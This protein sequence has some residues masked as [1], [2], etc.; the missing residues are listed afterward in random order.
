MKAPEV[1]KHVAT[2]VSKDVAKH[3]S[4][5]VATALC[6]IFAAPLLACGPGAVQG[7]V[8]GEDLSAQDAVVTSVTFTDGSSAA[9]VWIA[10][11][12]NFCTAAAD[13]APLKDTSLVLLQL[14]IVAPDGTVVAA[15]SAGTYTLNPPA[16]KVGER[17]AIGAWFHIGGCLDDHESANTGTVTITHVL[18]T[19]S[20]LAEMA[21]SISLAF[22]HGSVEGNF[23]AQPCAKVAPHALNCR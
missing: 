9:Q 14:G 22:G 23:Q 8:E 6:L 20:G 3:L 11:A 21:G 16:L 7:T 10:S 19:E 2:H 15:D 18:K 17:V 5:E 1:S 4:K 13:T 12:S